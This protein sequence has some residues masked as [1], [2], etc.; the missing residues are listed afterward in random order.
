[1]ELLDASIKE[2]L[3]HKM[4]GDLASY[5]PQLTDSNLLMCCTCCRFLPYE[6]FSLEHIIPQQALADD[7]KG[8]KFNPKT[9]ANARSGNILLCSKPLSIKGS[10]FYDNGCNSWKGRSYDRLI[11]ET[12]N[13]HIFA[14]KHRQFSNQHII[15]VVC[16]AY[17]AMVFEFGYQVAL[18]PSGLLLRQQFFM[19]RKFHRDMPARCQ[20]ILSGESPVY[21]DEN[22]DFW[23]TP[24]K[25]TID[26]DSCYIAFINMSFILPISRDPRVPIATSILIT[27]LK[28]KM[29][30]DFR[31]IFE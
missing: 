20:M 16:A 4:R 29:R 1:M 30:P 31:T 8:I 2:N 9:T 24:F 19:P 10:R 13:R 11:R 5:M 25:F 12:L 21:N 6:D 3:W 22:L 7:L 17:I 26:N 23:A 15:A 28:F 18:T 14:H 27:P